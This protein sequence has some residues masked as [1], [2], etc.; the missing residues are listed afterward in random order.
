MVATLDILKK[1]TPERRKLAVEV[2]NE[3]PDIARRLSIAGE[4]AWNT[5][6]P[7]EDKP[8]IFDEQ[9]SFVFNRDPVSFLIGGNGSGTSEAAAHKIGLF[10]LQQQP[11][12]RANTPFWIISNTYEQVCGVLWGEKLFGNGHIPACEVDWGNIRWLSSKMDWPLSVPLKPWPN[13]P[14]KNWLLEFKSY[15]QGRRAMQARSIGGFC[16]SE[17]FPWQLFVETLRGCREYMFSGGQFA[18]FTPIE[19][20][21]CIAVGKAMDSPELRKAKWRFYRCSTKANR[22]NLADGWFDQFFATVAEESVET[23]MTGALAIFEGLIYQTF[24]S[25]V[26]VVGDDV[27]TFSFTSGV[28]HHCAF[29][30]GA[31]AE[32]P[33][34]GVWGY[35]DGVGD[36]KIYDEYWCADQGKVLMDH[37]IEILARS[38]CWGWPEPDYFKEP[39][40]W[41]VDYVEQV[42]KRV[43]EIRP[44]G[45]IWLSRQQHCESFGDPS[46][47]DCLTGFNN[48]GIRTFPAANSVYKG[49]DCVRTH[50]KVNPITGKPRILIHKR[51]EH[52]I[53][54]LRK[55][56]WKQSKKDTSGRMLN[57]QVAAPVP[58]K[59]DDDVAD[60]FRYLLYSEQRSRGVEPSTDSSYHNSQSSDRFAKSVGIPSRRS[61]RFR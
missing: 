46:R 23:R 41:Q 9:T 22:P 54:E 59:R 58:L 43:R 1:L 14:G 11:P 35:H 13:R 12:P 8:E 10:M 40:G 51:C 25:A 61:S 29:D 3:R 4:S 36:W 37:A 6:V 31:S 50:L 5:F 39:K 15:E 53:E 32:H 44:A 17:Q 24:N 38:I 45:A 57:P 20:E 30:W 27:I 34:A 56:R 2:L 19:P 18:E 55:H 28:R 26:H 60:A 7:R 52:L 16:F 42:R 47:P 49:I 33:F 48:Y 21:L